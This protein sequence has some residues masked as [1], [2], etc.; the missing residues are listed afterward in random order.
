MASQSWRNTS[1]RSKVPEVKCFLAVLHPCNT[2]C[3]QK[4]LWQMVVHGI[5][6][7]Q[8]PTVPGTGTAELCFQKA[9]SSSTTCQPKW[10]HLRS[11]AS[12]AFG[13]AP[14]LHFGGPCHWENKKPKAEHPWPQTIRPWGP[15]LVP[16]QF[17]LSL[18]Q[19]RFSL[20]F[21]LLSKFSPY[22]G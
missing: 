3:K 22:Q 12:R 17:L 11:S 4:C 20:H 9:F 10:L 13:T 19:G 15:Q 14:S 8:T 18:V 5:A 7:S 6:T 16:N 1:G 21:P 2:R